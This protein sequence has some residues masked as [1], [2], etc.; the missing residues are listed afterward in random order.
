MSSELPKYQSE[1]S[2]LT[3][4]ML[5]ILA[6]YHDLTMSLDNLALFAN[7]FDGRLN[8]HF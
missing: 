4:L 6:D 5:R 3:L 7:S 2:A 1:L 8:F